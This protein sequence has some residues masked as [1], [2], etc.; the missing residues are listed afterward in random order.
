[1]PA[2]R[3]L[4]QHS[5]EAIDVIDR[6]LGVWLRETSAPGSVVLSIAP[7]LTRLSPAPSGVL[8]SKGETVNQCCPAAASHQTA[9]WTNTWSEPVMD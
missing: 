7:T 1:M 8:T 3:T 2:A 9:A 6:W 5:G 4:A